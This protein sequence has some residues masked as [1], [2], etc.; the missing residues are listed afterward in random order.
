MIDLCRWKY[1][2]CPHAREK[3][4]T[5]KLILA[6]ATGDKF[7]GSGLNVAQTKECLTEYW[8]SQNIM[9]MILMELRAEFQS[10]GEASEPEDGQKRKAS[11]PLVS[12]LNKQTKT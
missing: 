3:L 1:Q 11:S 10:A 9:G 4:L 2:V 5:S 8:P 7:W 12:D 6:E